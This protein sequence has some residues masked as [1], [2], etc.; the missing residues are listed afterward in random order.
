MYDFLLS[1][2]K[3]KGWQCLIW[4]QVVGRL[5]IG[6]GFRFGIILGPKSL[7]FLGFQKYVD[8]AKGKIHVYPCMDHLA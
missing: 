4:W 7:I 5:I 6:L 2:N 1:K 8:S 3:K